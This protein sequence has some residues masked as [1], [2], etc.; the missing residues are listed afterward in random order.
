MNDNVTKI[1]TADSRDYFRVDG[2]LYFYWEKIKPSDLEQS[3]KKIHVPTFAQDEDDIVGLMVDAYR[4]RLLMSKLEDLDLRGWLLEL[5]QIMALMKRSFDAE[6]RGAKQKVFA[7]TDVNISGSGMAFFTLEPLAIKDL[8]RVSLFF[9]LYPYSFLS[10]VAS[11]VKCEKHENGFWNKLHFENIPERERDEI[12]RFVNQCQ[13][14]H[15]H[16]SQKK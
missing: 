12:L 16:D 4:E 8:L 13:R 7:K 10:L 3:P 5:Q 6:L 11:V 1:P 14:E 9:P 15:M 2:R